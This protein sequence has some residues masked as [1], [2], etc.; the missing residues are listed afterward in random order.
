MSPGSVATNVQESPPANGMPTNVPHALRRYDAGLGGK[1]P[2]YTGSHSGSGG[3]ASSKSPGRQT[4]GNSASP[5]RQTIGTNG[6]ASAGGRG[7]H[8]REELYEARMEEELAKKR[9]AETEEL[10]GQMKGILTI[11]GPED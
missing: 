3:D 8:M 4:N 5:G 7:G 1:A 2:R 11:R 6:N 10:H 9:R